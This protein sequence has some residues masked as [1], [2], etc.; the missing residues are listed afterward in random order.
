MI[1]VDGSNITKGL[2]NLSKKV[3]ASVEKSLAKVV[4]YKKATMQEFDD[5]EIIPV[6]SK[7]MLNVQI[8]TT[9]DIGNEYAQVT[10]T[11]E[12]TVL[13]VNKDLKELLK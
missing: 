4:A 7:N 12:Q 13:Q 10:T 8:A 5:T 2:S 3:N 11:F 6:A 1:T 9:K